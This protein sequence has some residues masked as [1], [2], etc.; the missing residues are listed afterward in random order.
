MG[1]VSCCYTVLQ[2]C[3]MDTPHKL[4]GVFPLI[5]ALGGFYYVF[6]TY[7]R[8]LIFLKY[9]TIVINWQY[10]PKLVV[11]VCVCWSA[12]TKN[13][14]LAISVSDSSWPQV[15]IP[16]QEMLT[17]SLAGLRLWGT[18]LSVWV[19]ERVSLNE[20][21]D[22]VTTALSHL[23]VKEGTWAITMTTLWIMK[24]LFYII[25]L[26]VNNVPHIQALYG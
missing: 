26:H 8:E 12:E 23:S 15:L 10:F 18:A 4:P 20:P 5:T 14:K 22:E 25:R 3:F 2:L 17:E 7:F 19:C 11:C 13:A 6:L 21:S 16:S 1:R 24:K 9:L